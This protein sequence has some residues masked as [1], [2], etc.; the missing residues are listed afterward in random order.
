MKRFGAAIAAVALVSAACGTADS[1]DDLAVV[2][3]TSILGDIAAAVV[4]DDAV[5]EVLTPLGADPHDYQPSSRQ[6]ATVNGADLVIATG[7]G[8]EEGLIDV[9][10]AAEDDGVPVLWIGPQVDPLPFEGHH[11][12]DHDDDVDSEDHEGLDPHFWLDPERAA[13]AADLIATALETERAGSG[14][15]DRAAAYAAELAVLD[16]EIRE[17]LAVVPPESRRLVTNHDALGYFATRYD[18]EVVGVVIPGGSTLADPSSADLAALVATIEA[19]GV[20]AIFAE[21]IESDSLANAVASEVDRPIDIV[22]L[23][24][25]SLGPPGS[26]A[27][28]LVE[29][30]RTNA[31][32]IA[33]ALS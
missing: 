2:A 29:M 15:T 16:A 17:A 4:G 9:L 1:D 13:Q 21:T 32:R 23:F 26:G 6:V 19:S 28:T 22:E 10:E 18:F 31:T 12:D 11:D 25:G 14:W 8:L 3:T 33:E 7:L 24:T 27:E 5:V 20:G 30:L